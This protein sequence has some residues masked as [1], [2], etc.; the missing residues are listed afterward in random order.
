[1][2]AV[3]ARP[4]RVV[5]H[6]GA[7]KTGTTMV[8]Q[9]L[10]TH[11]RVLYRDHRVRYVPRPDLVPMF[12]WGE[13]LVADP[14]AFRGLLADFRADRRARVL[15][16]SY[17]NLCG[18]PFLTGRPGLYPDA[19][20]H[21]EALHAELAGL[22]PTILLSVRPQHELIESYYLQH[23]NVGGSTPFGEWLRRI[24]LDAL[25]W[26]PLVSALRSTFGPDA[27]RLIDFRRLRLG[28]EE[29]V[30]HVLDEA[31]IAPGLVIDRRWLGRHNP[32]LS[33]AG[34]E[35]ALAF[36][37]RFRDPRERAVVRSY[38]QRYFSNA[39]DPERPT[40]LG[41]QLRA[42]LA[43]RYGAEYEALFAARLEPAT[44]ER[45]PA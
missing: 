19:P 21:L 42:D 29:F 38:L 44:C 37:R 33:A 26:L 22:D 41:A 9:C 13:R 35:L 30:R 5:F 7:H 39:V 1:V 3:L 18:H 27:V 10:R 24:D 15:L 16:A 32:S 6:V 40:L 25:S 4:R 43:D 8:Q 28:A 11:A 34:L 31:G 23:V 36:N 2:R 12:G 14:T 45:E 20:A 17:D